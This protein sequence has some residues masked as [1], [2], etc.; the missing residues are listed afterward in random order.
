[1]EKAQ[2]KAF[3]NNL[4]YLQENLVLD[5]TFYTGLIQKEIFTEEMVNVVKV[6]SYA[7][8]IEEFQAKLKQCGLERLRGN[9]K[10]VSRSTS[11]AS[12][13]SGRFSP[14]DEL[15][16][17]IKQ[18]D[19]TIKRH[20]QEYEHLKS[21]MEKCQADNESLQELNRHYLR[22]ISQLDDMQRNETSNQAESSSSE[23]AEI[24][25]KLEAAEA[26]VVQLEKDLEEANEWLIETQEELDEVLARERKVKVKLGLTEDASERKVN[27]R[28]RELCDG[29]SGQKRE[30]ESLR[31]ELA[32]VKINRNRLEDKVTSLSREKEQVEFHMRQQDLFIKKLVRMKNAKETIDS[33]SARIGC[34]LRSA[35]Q[36]STISLSSLDV[37]KSQL[38]LKTKGDAAQQYCVLCRKDI[39]HLHSVCWFHFRALRNGKW[40]CCRDEC[41]HSAGCLRASHFYIEFSA[42]KQVFLTNGKQYLP[43]T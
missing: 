36:I 14:D 12:D 43:L 11:Q 39:N 16:E 9:V 13:A 31:K 32:Q 25:E 34:R 8:D 33:A 26:Q 29:G 35:A 1:M 2:K 15:R 42:D 23:Y 38:K 20:G 37:D 5:E 22:I 28:I 10:S 41:F 27:Q 4:I 30:L 3:D 18:K 19:Q 24:E 17:I 6:A 7:E 40:Q 21:I